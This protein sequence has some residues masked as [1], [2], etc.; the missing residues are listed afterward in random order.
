[1]LVNPL[2]IDWPNF[3][4]NYKEVVTAAVDAF[5]ADGNA[6]VT[7]YAGTSDVISR[8]G[9]YNQ[10]WDPKAFPG[11]PAVDVVDTLGAQQIMFCFGPG[12][13]DFCNYGHPLLEGLLGEFLPPPEGVDPV[14]FYSCLS[15]FEG[16]IDADLWGDGSAFATAYDERIVTPGKNAVELL[17]SKPY[18][19]RMYTTISP[20]EML[21]DPVFAENPDLPEIASL[22]VAQ[23][24]NRCDGH[25]E[26]VLPDGREVF[27]PDDGPWPE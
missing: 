27:V 10:A 9:I 25:A 11:L 6:F 16:M 19:T 12:D 22:R 17:N 5:Q 20:H 13:G 7:E 26:Y 8:G 2:K 23:K 18:V 3:A 15:C 14:E 4:A 24:L 1:M 21:E